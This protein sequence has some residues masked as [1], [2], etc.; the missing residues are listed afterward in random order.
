MG[1]RSV[2]L[3]NVS[4]LLNRSFGRVARSGM[5]APSTFTSWLPV[6]RRPAVSQVSTTSKSPRGIRNAFSEELPSSWGTPSDPE[7]TSVQVAL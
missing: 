4:H 2:G 3:A 6:P 5:K 1:L 7:C